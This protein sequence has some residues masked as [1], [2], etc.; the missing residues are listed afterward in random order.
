MTRA[1]SISLRLTAAAVAT[2]AV[3][4]LSGCLYA[5]I[6]TGSP[7][8]APSAGTETDA[9]A[10]GPLR[11]D[12]DLRGRARSHERHLHR[13]GRRSRRR[14]RVEDRRAGRRQRR[15]DLRHG[16]RHLHGT[17]LA[18]SHDRRGRGPR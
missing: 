10:D 3:L 14:R 6:P 15:V 18:G 5:Q 17:V 8:D 13:V 7:S 9:P 2:L 16:R 11:F 1:F 12:P 4:S